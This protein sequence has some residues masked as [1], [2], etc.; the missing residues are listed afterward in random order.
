MLRPAGGVKK[1]KRAATPVGGTGGAVPSTLVPFAAEAASFADGSHL[2]P[3]TTARGS[4]HQLLLPAKYRHV[5]CLSLLFSGSYA[6][7]RTAPVPAVN[8][9]PARGGCKPAYL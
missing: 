7:T 5:C 8:K 9:V 6:F 2:R 3:G 4:L 1:K